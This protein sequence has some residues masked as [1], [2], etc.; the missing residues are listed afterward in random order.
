M[1]DVRPMEILV[2]FTPSEQAP[3]VKMYKY[4]RMTEL[5]H[6]KCIV[7]KLSLDSLKRYC[8]NM[9]TYQGAI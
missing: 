8:Y 4:F 9:L 7:Y 3:T 1:P 5:L 6:L 2:R